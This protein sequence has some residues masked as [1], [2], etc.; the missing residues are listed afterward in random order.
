M[1]RKRL[2]KFIYLSIAT[3]A[4][5]IGLKAIAYLMTRSVGLLSDALESLVNLVAAIVA[6]VIFQ[7]SIKPAN[8]EHN[9]GHRKAEYFS[10]IIEGSLIML[11]A[12]AIIW[13]AVERLLFPTEITNI[14]LGVTISLIASVLNLLTA[15]VLLRQGKKHR[16]ILLEADGQHLMSDVWTSVGV[17]V[18]VALSRL[19][20]L[21]FLD[22]VVAILMAMHILRTG[23][24]LIG[25]SVHGLLD[26]AISKD[27]RKILLKFLNN[28]KSQNLHYHKLQTR[29]TGDYKLVIFHLLVPDSWTVRH[30]HDRAH[31][32]DAAICQLLGRN[33]DV[34][35]HIEPHSHAK[36]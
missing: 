11:A 13:T 29:Q 20:G 12:S 21:T 18:G 3:A 28:L 24:E 5:T 15:Q 31:E 30:A 16:S 2:R 32:I 19:T 17:I 4:A 35:I 26:P 22:P 8:K 1:N 34:S 10:S 33:T 7:Y 27:Q 25:R 36:K 9:F 23:F 6:L 14:D